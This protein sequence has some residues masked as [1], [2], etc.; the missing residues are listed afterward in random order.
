MAA[1]LASL[2]MQ[3]ADDLFG[4][5][6]GRPLLA[7]LRTDS[8]GLFTT[9]DYG[10]ISNWW[11]VVCLTS[12]SRVDSAIRRRIY[13]LFDVSEHRSVGFLRFI[14]MHSCTSHESRVVAGQFGTGLAVSELSTYRAVMHSRYQ[15]TTCSIQL[16][17]NSW[18]IE[19]EQCQRSA[20]GMR[21]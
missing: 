12:Y 20:A 14:F 8:M 9:L 2:H 1:I 5:P 4:G 21:H 15:S 16:W 17:N 18:T 3:S 7:S 11:R 13:F 6:Q 19:D 10:S